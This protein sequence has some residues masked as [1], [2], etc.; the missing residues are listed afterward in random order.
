M[1]LEIRPRPDGIPADLGRPL[2][3][4]SKSH[5]QRVMLLAAF[6]PGEHRLIGCLRSD[7]TEVL[8]QALEKLGARLRWERDV[9]HVS[10][11]PD[12][13][14]AR[15]EGDVHVRE[16][17]TALRMLLMVVPLLGGRLRIDGDEGLR[18]RPLHMAVDVLR[19]AKVYVA[20]DSAE[21]DGDPGRAVLPL[22]VDGAEADW[23]EQLVVDAALSSQAAS[24]AILG[25]ALRRILLH[26]PPLS[27]RVRAPAAKDYVRMTVS[28]LRDFGF[29]VRSEERSGD[30]VVWPEP[31]RGVDRRDLTLPPDPSALVYPLALATMHGLAWSGPELGAVVHPDSAVVEDLQQLRQAPGTTVILDRVASRPDTFPALAAV[32]AARDGET[33]FI[34]APALR[35]KE[36]DR[37]QA[38]ARGLT[39]AGAACEALPDGLIV[40]GPLR[41]PPSPQPLLLPAAPD[42]RVVMA[43]SLLGTLVPQG[44]V[45]EHT[46]A[47]AKS[48][49]TF[50]EWLHAVADVRPRDAAAR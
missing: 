45:V 26:G 34:G 32:A 3:P 31:E 43:L 5:T 19:Q 46:Q 41:P 10:G 48:W 42:H 50:F 8:A 30:V 11:A 13:A 9:L 17:G 1:E 16:N 20:S 18:R 44:V 40:R 33:R 38:M 27:M 37:V 2:L 21:A 14:A 6:L 7:D 36:S 47:V 29:I 25:I 39:A 23:P 28:V 22:I 24:G 35:V 4:P 12:A 15:P 49:P